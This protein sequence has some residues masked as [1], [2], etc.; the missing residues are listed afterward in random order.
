MV[1]TRLPLVSVVEHTTQLLLM[2][3]ALAVVWPVSVTRDPLGAG[4]V[5]H[6]TRRVVML[7]GELLESQKELITLTT[8]LLKSGVT[9]TTDYWS[10]FCCP[11]RCCWS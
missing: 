11:R 7:T 8:M 5:G 10:R 4:G 3:V 1:L 9:P 2:V 6:K